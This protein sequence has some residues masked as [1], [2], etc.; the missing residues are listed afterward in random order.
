MKTLF[1]LFVALALFACSDKKTTPKKETTQPEKVKVDEPN[2]P[3]PVKNTLTIEGDLGTIDQAMVQKK[4]ETAKST[5][6][7]CIYKG[8]G[9]DTWIGG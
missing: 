8:V 3:A 4:F 9:Q 2:K 1:V 6:D 7:Q 5:L